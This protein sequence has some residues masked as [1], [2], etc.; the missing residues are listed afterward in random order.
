MKKTFQFIDTDG[1]ENTVEFEAVKTGEG[2]RRFGV[3]AQLSQSGTVLETAEAGARF[4][5]PEETAAVLDMLC[6]FQVTPCTL[7]DVI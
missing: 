1:R 3:R 4:I 7:C 5:T 2:C 6:E